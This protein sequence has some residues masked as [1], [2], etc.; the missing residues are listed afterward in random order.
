MENPKKV[1]V[2]EDEI[3]VAENI[4]KILEN[5]GYAVV[6][7]VDSGREAI[8]L[9]ENTRPNVVLMDIKLKGDID[10]IEAAGEIRS[11]FDVPIIYHT[12]Y[13]DE[14]TVQRA[15]LTEPFGYILKP[16]GDERRLKTAIEIALC[17]YKMEKN[18]RESEERYRFLIEKQGEGIAC[19]G[20]NEQFT[21]CNP[22]AE[23]IFGVL[24]GTLVDRNLKEFITPEMFETIR[25]ETGKCRSGKRNSYELEIMRPDGEKRQL[26]ITATP[27]FDDDDRFAGTFEI[28]RD[29][30][31]RKRAQEALEQGNKELRKEIAERKKAEKHLKE[32][33]KEKE[34]LLK[35]IHHRVKNNLQV[36]SSL[37]YLQSEHINE[38]QK[39]HINEQQNLDVLKES[40]DRVR[41]MALVH[42]KLYQ[43]QD[44]ARINFPEYVRKL[45]AHLFQSYEANLTSITPSTDVDDVSLDIDMAIPCGLLINELISNSLKHAFPDGR[46]GEVKI[47]FHSDERGTYTLT[48]SDNGIGFP[49]DLDFRNTESM[50]LRLVMTLTKQLEGEIQ[51]DKNHGTTFKIMFGR[52]HSNEKG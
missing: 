50:G 44:L 40:Q 31:E 13:A 3:I 52:P 48:V 9:T 8:K 15:K 17:K 29:D 18:L 34:V 2:V 47:D 36:V 26:F 45:T 19:L 5:V 35:E 4:K 49:A 14:D 51:L 10:G 24:P 30:T 7:A 6:G 11:R 46:K 21:F 1:L 23:E 25:K 20:P 28:F 32:S 27:W 33:L 41:S 39:G 38:Q 42:E 37:L 16:F 12:A 22:V 43:S